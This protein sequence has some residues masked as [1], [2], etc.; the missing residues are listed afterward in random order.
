MTCA[1]L[2]LS[3]VSIV[4]FLVVRDRSKRKVCSSTLT[5]QAG[6]GGVRCRHGADSLA[7]A[8][9]EGG[10]TPQ[11]TEGD[12]ATVVASA[13][14]KKGGEIESNPHN[15]EANT[16]RATARQP[17]SRHLSIMDHKFSLMTTRK[18]ALGFGGPV[19][20]QDLHRDGIMRGC[21]C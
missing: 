6:G 17:P 14:E 13:I 3:L 19:A 10:W 11:P 4:V 2:S 16:S 18:L 7:T 8:H 5:K 21:H 15:H 20:W 9:H 1:E 12:K